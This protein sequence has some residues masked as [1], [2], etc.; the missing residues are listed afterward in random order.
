[1]TQKAG[2]TTH[3]SA[4]KKAV[5]SELVKL[6]EQYPIVGAVNIENLPAS[7]FQQMRAKFR[8]NYAIAVAKKRVIK[9]AL[10]QA[11]AKR[12]GIE[13]LA[14][15]LEGMPAL[16][17]TKDNPFKLYKN[18]NQNKS[19]APAKAGQKAPRDIIVPA[20]PTSFA[21]GPI[22]GQ[23][24]K[25]GIKA[26]IEAGKIVIKADSVAAKE[27]TVLTEEL[28]G[29]LTRLDI[30]PMEIGLN[31]V[32]AYEN[33]EVFAKGVLAIDDAKVLADLQNMAR[34]SFNLAIFS[35]IPNKDTI[36][37]L[38]GKSFREAKAVTVSE[39]LPV[40][41]LINDVIGR[42]HLCAQAV[43]SAANV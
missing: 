14:D 35:A 20:G 10:E 33:G 2:Y 8:S 37:L 5:V 30:K 1:M 4:D 6:F 29:I 32:S 39:G 13:K 19:P 28:A 38:V 43:K 7:Q 22:I 18:L 31:L 42:A 25:F 16:I 12:P 34:Q 27:G 23:L 24:G 11:K 26:G 17:F 21:P 3:V 40:K 9:V 15:S 36:Q 41:E